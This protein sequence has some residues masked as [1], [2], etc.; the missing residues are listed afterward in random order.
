MDS[1]DEETDSGS[2]V[3]SDEGSVEIRIETDIS[4]KFLLFITL[5]SILPL[6]GGCLLPA[7]SIRVRL[8]DS[9]KLCP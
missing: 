5:Q 2:S 1:D 9:I 4:P 3:D 8:S 7:Y 6:E